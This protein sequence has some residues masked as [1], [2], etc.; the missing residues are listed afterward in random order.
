LEKEKEREREREISIFG[1]RKVKRWLAGWPDGRQTRLPTCLLVDSSLPI[2]SPSSY[3]P[4]APNT[5]VTQKKKKTDKYAHRIYIP[6]KG[7]PQSRTK[8]KKAHETK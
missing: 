6:K 1:V 5:S 3:D 7:S 2:L 8:N 4:R